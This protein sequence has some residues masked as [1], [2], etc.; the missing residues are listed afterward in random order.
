MRTAHRVE[1]VRAAEAALMRRLPDGELMRRAATGL[2]AVCL[3]LL[4]PAGVYG[5]PV[6]V[7]AGSGDNGGDA[8][9]AGA[10]LAGRGAAVTAVLLSPRRT[11]PGG[12]AALRAAGGRVLHAGPDDADVLERVAV[13]LSRA[14]LVL[15]GIVGIGGRG[16]LRPEAARLL[17]LVEASGATVVAV[18]LPS[19]LD[20]DTGRVSGPVLRAHLTV[21]FGTH[22]P[23]LLLSPGAGVA[24]TV[25]L[26][27]IGLGPELARLAGGPDGPGGGPALYCLQHADVAAVLPVPGRDTDKYGRGVV[28]LAAGSERYPGAAVLAVSGAVRSGAG[29]VRY[30]GSVADAVLAAHPEVLVHRGGPREAGRVQAWVVGPGLG[31]GSAGEE[32]LGEVLASDVPVL[33][34]ADGLGLLAARGPEPL[35]RDAPTLFTPHA[36]EAARLLGV[37]RAAVEAEPLAHALR[38][39]D[40]YG[41]TVLLKGDRTIITEPAAPGGAEGLGRAQGP[42]GDGAGAEA[43]RGGAGDARERRVFVNTTGT[44][45]LATAGSG[46]V[47]AGLVGGLLAAGLP[48]VEAAAVGAYLHGLAGRL[49]A[50]G[51]PT[52]APDVARALPEAWR[53]VAS[54]ATG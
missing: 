5:A 45:W 20:A 42:G 52:T 9:F 38:L 29:A 37:E 31:T 16:G 47:L 54:T 36:G 12:L 8:L 7:L 40:A 48:V 25:H 13:P 51:A 32:A 41:V 3:E 39:A 19:G 14:R 24:G 10:R 17:P 44:G 21:T 50:S 46:D 53:Q 6:V 1:Q 26:V 15:D 22:K 35:Y 34:D 18:D 11:H 33:V 49:A 28:G 23:G 30:A 4:S 27:D 43:G 2:A